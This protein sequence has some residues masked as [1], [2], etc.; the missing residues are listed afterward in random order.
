MNTTTRLKNAVEA[1][2]DSFPGSGYGHVGLLNEAIDELA[3]SRAFMSELCEWT[4]IDYDTEAGE[5]FKTWCGEN[6]AANLRIQAWAPFCPCCG[7][8]LEVKA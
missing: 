6:I 4:F 1:L 8:K 5:Y 2:N 3:A 7:R